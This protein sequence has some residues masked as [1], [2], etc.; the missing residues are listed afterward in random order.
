M[1]TVSTVLPPLPRSDRG[2]FEK[3]T[4]DYYYKRSSRGFW[5]DNEVTHI[6]D[7]PMTRCDHEFTRKGPEVQCTKCHFG[8]IGSFGVQN[9]KLLHNGEVLPLWI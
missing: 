5:G 6:E 7:G 3:H 8:L 9:G 1:S 4:F 2:A